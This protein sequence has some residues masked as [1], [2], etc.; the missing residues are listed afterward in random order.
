MERFSQASVLAI[1]GLTASDLRT[2]AMYVICLVI[3]VSIH[4]FAHA[5]AADRLGDP[6]PSREGRLT[7]NPMSHA[8]PIGTLALPVAAGLFHLPLL[9]WGRPVP[10]QPSFYTRKISMRGGLALVSFAGPLSN[11]LQALLTLVVLKVLVVAGV[12]SRGLNEILLTFFQLNLILFAFNLLPL[13]P[14]DGG[15]ILAWLLPPKLSYIDEFLAR[16]G[17]LILL[18]LV[19]VL[20][21]VLHVML[22]PILTLARW[23]LQA[24]GL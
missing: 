19:I 20:P 3:A 9:G 22:S 21:E 12:S 17:G 2:I 7:L 14:L 11:F 16:W 8:D 5:F 24:I 10:T 4:E 15:K 13:H 18:I 6:T 23:S 1:V